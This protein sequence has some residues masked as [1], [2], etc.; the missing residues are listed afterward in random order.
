MSKALLLPKI[1]DNYTFSEK[2]LKLPDI[3]SHKIYKTSK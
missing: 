3:L 2:N 1:L